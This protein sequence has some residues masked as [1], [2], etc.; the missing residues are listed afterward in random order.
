M[1]TPWGEEAVVI[2][3]ATTAGDREQVHAG[4]LWQVVEW[5]RDHPDRERLTIWLPER[6]VKPVSFD[7]A[8]IREL[9]LSKDRPSRSL[10]FG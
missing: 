6:R 8:A 5:V 1:T 10:G 9:L 4:P 3:Q 2:R 7:D